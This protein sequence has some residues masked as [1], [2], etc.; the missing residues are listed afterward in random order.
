MVNSSNITIIV[1]VNDKMRL[2]RGSIP[3]IS[4]DT[5]FIVLWGLL[6][7]LVKGFLFLALFENVTNHLKNELTFW[8]N[9]FNFRYEY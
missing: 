9:I 7:R 3:L 2:D 5:I 1:E 6:T 8:A 4:I